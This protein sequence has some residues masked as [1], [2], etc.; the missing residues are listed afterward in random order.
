MD[1]CTQQIN[2]KH[3]I[4]QNPIKESGIGLRSAHYKDIIEQKPDTGW[5]EV[6]PENYF[7]GGAHRHYLTKAREL[8][9]LSFHAVGLSMGSDQAVSQDH[10]NKIKALI[11]IYQPFQ[12]SDHASWS[13]SG[14]AHL[15]DLLPLPYTTEAL[16]R[17]C[18]NVSCVQ[19]GI[20]RKMLVENPSSYVAYQIDDMTE[21]EF[22]NALTQKTGCG[23][24]LDINN[25]YVQ[26]RNHGFDAYHY[27]NN[28]KVDAVG[29]M[30]LAGH[31]QRTFGDES[32]LVDSHNRHVCDDVWQLY[33]HAINR[34]GSVP[35]LIE[36]DADLPTLQTLVAE[37]DK[38]QAIINAHKEQRHEAA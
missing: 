28:I 20:G 14:N 33:R 3:P 35:T 36:W 4:P 21:Y 22:M 7:G 29:E 27:I 10:I 31:I 19:D 34:F 37:A 1:F 9:P 30:H 2:S 32:I 23:L 11:D 26:S 6:H 25:I 38:A 24:L 15:N 5:I 8:Y 17:L 12:I 13:A 16:Q 18:D